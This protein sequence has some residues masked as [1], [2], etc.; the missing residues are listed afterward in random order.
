MFTIDEFNT[1]EDNNYHTE[2]GIELAKQY[3]T[4]E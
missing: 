1:N 3:G 2:N 4:Q